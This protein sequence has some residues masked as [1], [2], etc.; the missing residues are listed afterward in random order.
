MAER[1]ENAIGQ[2][3]DIGGESHAQKIEGINF[4][5]R[6]GQANQIHGTLAIFEQRLHRGFRAIV[7]EIAQERIAGAERKKTKRDALSPAA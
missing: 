7:G 1:L 6:V 3:G 4:A 5:G 2:R